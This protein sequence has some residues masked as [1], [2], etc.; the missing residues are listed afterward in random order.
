MKLPKARH[1]LPGRLLAALLICCGLSATVLAAEV[2]L[3]TTRE[4]GL[5][6][7]LLAKFTANTGIKVRTV[8]VR[9]GLA[10]RVAAE[11]RRSPADVLMVVDFGNLVDLVDRGVTQPLRSPVLEAAIPAQLRDPQGHWFALSLRAR[12][13][14]AAKDRVPLTQFHYEDLA[15]PEWKGK[16]CLRS[17]QHAYNTAVIAA[18]IAHHGEAAAETWLR[19]VKANL[20]RRPGG[21]DREVAR[22]ILGQLCD[23]GLGNSYYVGRMRSGSGGPEQQQ[24]GE[25]I[26]VL[27]PTFTNGGT[28]VNVSGAAL[29][30]NAPNRDAA[31]KLLE[32]LVSD[33]AQHEYA[34]TNYEYPVKPGVKTDPLIDALGKLQPDTL[35]LAQIA[36]HR[37][38][39]SLL[40][41]RIGF[42]N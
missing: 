18:Y 6:D 29:A 31:V 16:V 42:D 1:R 34:S 40:A 11:G 27:L 14:Y 33:A 21:G 22:D 28:H 10:E 25:A 41:E 12:V 17:A 32:F 7:P 3:Y 24:W 8:F 26:K 2:N 38:T 13:L 30:R 23:V 5:I 15:R 9:D 35:P 19:G 37:K 39:A 4:Q 20:A 36:A